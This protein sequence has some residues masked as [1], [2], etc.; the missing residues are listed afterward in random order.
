M[1]AYLIGEVPADAD[2][3]EDIATMSARDLLDQVDLSTTRD[4]VI[5][6]GKRARYEGLCPVYL[7]GQTLE[8]RIKTRLSD[9]DDAVQDA[10]DVVDA[11]IVSDPSGPT[12]P[13]G[14]SL[15]D[16]TMHGKQCP[17]G[18]MASAF[19]SDWEEEHA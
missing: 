2:T 18:Q 14:C 17:G 6:L 15:T 10:D 3:D 8:D 11:E 4:E 9:F 13:C 5:A 1:G 16:A 19:G 12:A 7:D